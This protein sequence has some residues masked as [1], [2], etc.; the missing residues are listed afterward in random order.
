MRASAVVLS[1]K[2]SEVLKNSEI[3]MK[4]LC[5]LI[6]DYMG[7]LVLAVAQH[8]RCHRRPAVCENK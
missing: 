6:S 3:E 5:K 8:Q 2:V 4:R 7:V 1:V